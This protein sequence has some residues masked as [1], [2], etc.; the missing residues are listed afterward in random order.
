M[1]SDR[2]YNRY[3]HHSWCCPSDVWSQFLSLHLSP[4]VQPLSVSETLQFHPKSPYG[5]CSRGSAVA[6]VPRKLVTRGN[7]KKWW[8]PTLKK[9]K[10]KSAALKPLRALPPQT[11]CTTWTRIW[12]LI[13]QPCAKSLTQQPTKTSSLFNITK[14]HSH[15]CYLGEEVATSD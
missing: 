2:W 9:N 8:I 4:F 13:P 5:V 6:F 1:T 12:V 3:N 10:K 15:L 11:I 7:T 14:H